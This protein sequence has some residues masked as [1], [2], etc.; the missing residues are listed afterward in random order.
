MRNTQSVDAT[1][2][3][4]TNYELRIN[5]NQRLKA[6]GMLDI[7]ETTNATDDPDRPLAE[8]DRGHYARLL[9]EYYEHKMSEGQGAFFTIV[10]DEIR[11][12]PMGRHW[13]R[14]HR[15]LFERWLEL[16]PT[17][18]FVDV[19]CG[20]GYYTAYL[21]RHGARTIGLDVSFSVLRLMHT[22]RW[23]FPLHVTTINSDVEILPIADASTDKVLCSHTLEHVLDD[24]RVLREICRILKPGGTA[25]LA[26][27]LK[28][29][30]PN[31][32]LNTVIGIGRALLKPGKRPA[33]RVPPGVLNRDLIGIQ[34]HIRHYSV[35]A[36]HR[37]IRDA[38]L[39]IDATAGMWFHDPRNWLVHYTQPRWPLY[40]IGTRLSKRW[41]SLGSALV[42]R[43]H[44]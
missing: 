21:A 32:V 43:V 33:P 26:I 4:I 35:E 31:R 10:D 42:V 2:S 27:P 12:K 7:T 34:S 19:G 25:V 6:I 40:E 28:Y 36:F 15:Q 1:C 23:P 30:T 9:K 11:T 3:Q 18:L 24:R 22:I 5:N 41:P 14:E 8:E 38:G 29:T 37:R 16:K 17:D 44:K 39:Q 20:E 13:M